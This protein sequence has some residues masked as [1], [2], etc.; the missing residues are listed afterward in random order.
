MKRKRM[1]HPGKIGN[2]CYK[3]RFNLYN[4]SNYIQ[5]V[6]ELNVAINGQNMSDWIFKN[7]IFQWE[8]QER[9]RR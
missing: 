6:S 8:I 3:G 1:Y 9:S 2:K 7:Y 5:C 4:I